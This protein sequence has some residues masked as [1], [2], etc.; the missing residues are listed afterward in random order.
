MS[1]VAN[2]AEAIERWDPEGA[3]KVSIRAAA[4]RAL[5]KGKI[6]LLCKGFGAR[7]EGRAHFAF[8]RRAAET[9]GDFEPS[10]FVNRAKGVEVALEIAHVRNPQSPQIQ[11]GA[12]PLRNDI[13]ACA[14]LDDI[15]IDRHAAAVVIPLFDARELLGKF[16]NGVNPL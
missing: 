6:H 14:A 2:G 16:V 8:K 1:A 10:S 12:R 9:T 13:G 15:G 7:E 11:N 4:N 3:G 5:T